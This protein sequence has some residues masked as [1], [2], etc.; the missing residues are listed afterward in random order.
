MKQRKE[1]MQD[2]IISDDL[3]PK[4]EKEA[5]DK[6]VIWNRHTGETQQVIEYQ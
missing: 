1:N 4:K 6:R 5:V 3:G 2:L